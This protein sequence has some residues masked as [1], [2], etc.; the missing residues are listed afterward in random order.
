MKLTTA[1]TPAFLK[2]GLFGN[3]GTGKT[4]TAAK[5]LSQFIKEFEPKA[6]LAM[7]DTEP[8]AGYIAPM[9]KAI[10]GKDLLVVQ[11]RAFGDLLEFA[12]LCRE[13]GYVALCDSVTHPWR[14]LCENYL[15]AK[16]ERVKG[17]GGRVETVR[18]SLKDWG[19]L[20]DTWAKFSER[21]SHDPVHWCICGREG[22]VWEDV[23]DGEGDTELKKTGVKMKTERETGY[24]PSLLVNMRLIGTE[25]TAHVVKDRFDVL[26]GLVS[27]DK[28]DIEFFRPHI[29]MLSIGG[30]APQAPAKDKVFKNT[31]GPNYET[32]QAQ[33]AGILENIKDDLVLVWPSTSAAEKKAKTKALRA[34]FG[35]SS[36]TQLEKDDKQFDLK[37]LHEGRKQLAVVIDDIRATKGGD[38]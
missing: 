36:W 21:L 10:T 17:V 4:Y 25:H 37:R 27:G 8:S 9:V 34:V 2:M 35:T 33:R 26:T 5:V 6:Q 15:D 1:T 30:K 14:S 22:D 38:E 23:Q 12:N 31:E 7:F 16:R 19:P 18:L 20:K 24:E 3:T 29:A 11:S 13:K 32:I 28:P